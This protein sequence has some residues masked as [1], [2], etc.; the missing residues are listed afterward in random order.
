[1]GH[2]NLIKYTLMKHTLI[3][4]GSKLLLTL[5]MVVLLIGCQSNLAPESKGRKMTT[6]FN[7]NSPSLTKLTH[8]KNP[9]A[10]PTNLSPQQ[11]LKADFIRDQA[12]E[13]ENGFTRLANPTLNMFIFPHLTKDGNPVP[14]Y[15]TNFKLYKSDHYALPQEVL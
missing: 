7:N 2:T 10:L 9:P 15:S 11:T 1:M 12:T 6:F 8:H 5:L 4:N 3:N 14:G 13:L